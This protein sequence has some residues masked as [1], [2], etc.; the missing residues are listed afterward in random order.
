MSRSYK[1]YPI[2]KDNGCRDYKKIYNRRLRRSK[3]FGLEDIP[4]GNA[5][6]KFNCPWNICD[7]KC[8]STWQEFQKSQ[9]YWDDYAESKGYTWHK[10]RTDK[11]LY[12]DWYT[13]YK[14]K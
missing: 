9:K 11:E 13:M 10:K 1:K 7:W 5:Y 8:T 2:C 4:N 14:M 3:K 6:R 12:H